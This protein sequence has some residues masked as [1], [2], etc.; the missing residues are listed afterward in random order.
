MKETK[1]DKIK[2]YSLSDGGTVSTTR[3]KN[4]L[5]KCDIYIPSTCFGEENMKIYNS[6]DE[7]PN[8]KGYGLVFL[9]NKNEMEIGSRQ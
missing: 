2:V 6:F 8:K 1:N 4:M 9:K 3:N 5:N 7:L